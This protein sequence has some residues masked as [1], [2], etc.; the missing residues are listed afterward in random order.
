M[1]MHLATSLNWDIQH[2][3]IKTAFLHGILPKDETVYLEQPEG[4]KEPRKEDW[5][6]KLRKSIYGMKQAGGIWN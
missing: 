4:F 6:M 5:V 2:I 1:L 3:D